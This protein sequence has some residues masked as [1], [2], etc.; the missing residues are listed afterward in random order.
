MSAIPLSRF[1]V[2][3]APDGDIGPG[4]STSPGHRSGAPATAEDP[5]SRLAD[6]RARG[7]EEGRAAA[8]AEYRAAQQ[9]QREEFEQRLAS[10]R[11]G[12]VE[13]EG[14]VLAEGVL[15][16]MRDIEGR[17]AESAA[18][19]LQPFLTAQL[20]R[21]VMDELVAA[22]QALVSKDA[23]ASLEICGPKDLVDAM[24]ERLAGTA[25]NATFSASDVPDVRV[26]VDQTVVQSRLAAWCAR[27]EAALA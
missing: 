27:I 12:W 20:Q 5:A 2:E 16:A 3:F 17:I 8:E 15:A 25:A 13:R 14:T 21:Q 19:V 23:S 9:T 4:R 11:R 18:R 7:Q 26:T 10:E 6:A 22:V 1:L 24:R